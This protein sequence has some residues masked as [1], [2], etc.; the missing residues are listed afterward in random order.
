MRDY[1]HLADEDE[2]VDDDFLADFRNA[3]CG[4]LRR[5]I[6]STSTVAQNAVMRHRPTVA[7]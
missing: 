2:E 6:N 5:E 4:N 3:R 1:E 7:A